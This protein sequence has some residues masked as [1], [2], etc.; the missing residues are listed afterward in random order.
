VYK[1]VDSLTETVFGAKGEALQK[2]T[3]GSETTQVPFRLSQRISLD[4]RF[5]RLPSTDDEPQLAWPVLKELNILNW[6]ADRCW[7][8]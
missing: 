2:F 6:V 7:P 8:I 4:V 5:P 3:V 1:N